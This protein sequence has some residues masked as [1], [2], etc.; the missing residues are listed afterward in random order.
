MDRQTDR[1]IQQLRSNHE[2]F[3]FCYSCNIQMI[4]LSM[5]V[6]ISVYVSIYHGGNLESS[7]VH[8][9]LSTVANGARFVWAYALPVQACACATGLGLEN[10]LCFKENVL[11]F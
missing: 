2:R 8:L 6:T 11:S 3:D 4:E 10:N 5:F 1:Q 9:S 7:F